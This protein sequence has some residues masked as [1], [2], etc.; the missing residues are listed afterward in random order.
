MF[1]A[2]VA[3]SC[4]HSALH[5][6]ENQKDIVFVANLAQLLQPFAAE[7]IVAA[8]ALNR[9]N[10]DGAISMPR[11]SMKSRISL[12]DFLFPLNRVGFAFRFRKREIDMRT[13]KRAANRISRTNPSCADRCS[14]GS[15]YNRCAREK[16]GGNEDL[17]AAFATTR[18]HVFAHLPIHR[19]LQTCS[20]LPSAP[21][22]INR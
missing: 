10:D 11:S 13:W 7:M 1:A 9:L 22:S 20:R 3:T 2:P 4:T 14:S 6:V 21:P 17:C 16:R 5:F 8:F 18:G 19:R 15:S 12:S